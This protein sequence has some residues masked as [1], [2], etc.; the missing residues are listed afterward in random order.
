MDAG[1]GCWGR[2]L[3]ESLTRLESGVRV[4]TEIISVEQNHTTLEMKRGL[5]LRPNFFIYKTELICPRFTM[6][7]YIFSLDPSLGRAILV[8]EYLLNEQIKTGTYPVLNNFVPKAL[9]ILWSRFS[10]QGVP[11][12]PQN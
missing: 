1:E 5:R 11:N 6:K 10:H 8:K 12:D 2:Y 7:M 3:P 9:C 4:S